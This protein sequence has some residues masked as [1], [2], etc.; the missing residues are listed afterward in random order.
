[1]ENNS[2]ETRLWT[3][4]SPLTQSLIKM[5]FQE[6]ILSED[7]DEEGRIRAVSQL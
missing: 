7:K 5:A 6:G 4:L 1:M 3:Y 2:E